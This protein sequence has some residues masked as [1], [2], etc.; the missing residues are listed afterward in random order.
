MGSDIFNF[1]EVINYD[2]IE[3]IVQLLRDNGVKEFS[4]SSN[5]SNLLKC[6]AQFKKFGCEVVG[7]V[8]VKD[9]MIYHKEK[10]RMIPALKLEIR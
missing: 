2:D 6:L 7:L 9:W 5:Y 3:L 8:E 10:A 1:Y 4:I